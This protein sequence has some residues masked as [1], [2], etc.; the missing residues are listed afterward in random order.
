M[1]VEQRYPSE[2]KK[3]DRIAVKYDQNDK[4]TEGWFRRMEGT[5]PHGYLV[6]FEP[7]LLAVDEMSASHQ[8]RFYKWVEDKPEPTERVD[9]SELRL[10]KPDPTAAEAPLL[11]RIGKLEHLL[12]SVVIVGRQAYELKPGDHLRVWWEDGALYSELVQ[13]DTK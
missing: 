7:R 12:S 11:K 5:S 10:N 1:W 6:Y 3:G 8:R 13:E 4:L 9:Q 2:F